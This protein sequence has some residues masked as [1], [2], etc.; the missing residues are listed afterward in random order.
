MQPS[1]APN[2]LITNAFTEAFLLSD[3]GAPRS[4]PLIVPEH[5]RRTPAV[6]AGAQKAK[7]SLY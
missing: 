2:S 4:A 7:S 6:A 1:A 5:R 3:G